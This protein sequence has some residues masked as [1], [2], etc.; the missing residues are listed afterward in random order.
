MCTRLHD[1]TS[2]S[3]CIDSILYLLNI[4]SIVTQR[5]ITTVSTRQKTINEWCERVEKNDNGKRG[6]VCANKT[7]ETNK[8]IGSTSIE[9]IYMCVC[10]RA[11][12]KSAGSAVSTH[13]QIEQYYC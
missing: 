10:A 1:L 9:C 8:T 5:A 4:K 6:K 7:K 13:V 12:C 3:K 11:L 2:N